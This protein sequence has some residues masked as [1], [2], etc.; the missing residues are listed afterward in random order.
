MNHNRLD[1]TRAMNA[2]TSWPLGELMRLA[3]VKRTQYHPGNQVTWVFDTNPNHT[4]ICQTRCS[5]CAFWRD[6]KTGYTLTPDQ[7]VTRLSPAIHQG[8]TT[9]LIQGGHNPA[10]T[11]ADWVTL[12]RTLTHAFPKVHLHPFSPPEIVFMAQTEKTT[13]QHILATLWEE[14]IRTLPGGGAEVLSDNIRKKISPL[15]CSATQWLELM[16]Q[17]HLMGFKTTATLMYGHI[18]TPNDLINHLMALR[19]LQ[20]RTGGFS[21]FVPWSFKPGDTPLG[22]RIIQSTIPID[23]LRIIATARLVLDNVSHIQSSWFS[24]HWRVGQLGLLAGADD[25]GGLLFEEHVLQQAGHAPRSNKER[26]L[27]AIRGMGFEPVQRDSLYRP[28]T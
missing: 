20:D 22:R 25:F 2:L 12:I 24:E 11:L 21:S 19:A 9:I 27:H 4:N 7:L 8:A 5:F 28:V 13:T 15:K 14:G 6:E 23:Y 10:I 18:E 1:P 26:V 3:H 17:A 16:E